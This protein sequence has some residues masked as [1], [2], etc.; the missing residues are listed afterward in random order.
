MGVQNKPNVEWCAVAHHS[1]VVCI[2]FGVLSTPHFLQCYTDEDRAK[3][4]K[5]GCEHGNEK[6]RHP[7]LMKMPK[8]SEIS[9][10]NFQKID[11]KRLREEKKKDHPQ[12]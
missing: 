8:L 4:G 7:F 1:R 3:I 9:V 5:C 12:P 11:K 6:A 2:H 10:R